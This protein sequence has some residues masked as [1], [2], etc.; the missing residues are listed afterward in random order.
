MSVDT[1]NHDYFKSARIKSWSK[2]IQP[3]GLMNIYFAFLYEYSPRKFY[4]CFSFGFEVLAC[5][6]IFLWRADNNC[7]N[8]SFCEPCTGKVLG[9][10]KKTV[11]F[12]YW[13]KHR[14]TINPLPKFPTESASYLVI[15]VSRLGLNKS[16]LENDL[17]FYISMKYYLYLYLKPM[18][19]AKN[20]H[21][22][23][24]EATKCLC[25]WNIVLQS[26]YLE[27]LLAL[28]FYPLIIKKLVLRF[29]IQTALCK[30]YKHLSKLVHRLHKQGN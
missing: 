13:F 29:C 28:F 10:K 7:K 27:T 8:L 23:N 14:L 9:S 20:K 30:I 5:G 1:G 4:S 11:Q 12:S 6:I 26:Y 22:F 15:C 21:R 24:L 17:I 18:L 16:R 19:A 25:K 3:N 2:I